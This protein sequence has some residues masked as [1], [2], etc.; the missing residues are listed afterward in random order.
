ME[1]ALKASVEA[2]KKHPNSEQM[3]LRVLA[4]DSR[5][6]EIH[7]Y[8][9]LADIDPTRYDGILDPRGMTALFD[10]CIN[11]AQAAAEYGK[12]LLQ[13]RFNANGIL[14]AI[15]DGCNNAGKFACETFPNNRD[16]AEVARAFRSTQAKECL[17]SF[18]TILIGVGMRDAQVKAILEAFH[19]EAGFS[20]P[21]I[22]LDDASPDNIAKIGAFISSSVSSTSSSLGTGG[23]SQNLGWT[24]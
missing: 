5:C 22:A 1:A 17:E 19:S 12:Q 3:M 18:A 11:G 16:A 24:S 15:T 4:F 2:L 9:P 13:D 20:T 6:D 14:I 8:I 23:P 7:G 10:A 21:M